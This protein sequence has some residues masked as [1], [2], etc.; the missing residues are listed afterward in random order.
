MSNTLI[1][2]PRNGTCTCEKCWPDFYGMRLCKTCGY[3]RC[4]CAE[5]CNMLCFGSNVRDQP[6]V[7][8]HPKLITI[9][10]DPTDQPP[11]KTT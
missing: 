9:N 2:A 1:Q 3:K 8:R 10:Y 11:N 6:K 5:D 7:E 4:P